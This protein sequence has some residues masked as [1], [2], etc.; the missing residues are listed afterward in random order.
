M[1][2]LLLP[3][4]TF[5]FTT[6]LSNLP[7]WDSI[8]AAP[9]A[10]EQPTV[11]S[12][13]E[14]FVAN[15]PTIL[16]VWLCSLGISLVGWGVASAI[17]LAVLGVGGGAAGSPSE[18]ASVVAS[19]ISNITQ[20]PFSILSSFVGV[21]FVAVP[22]MYYEIGEPIGVQQAFSILFNRPLRYL[23][24]GLLFTLATTVGFIL[25]ILPGIAVALVTPVYVNK[26]FNT[27]LDVVEA[28]KA[29][30]SAVYGTERGRTFLG[31]EILVGLVVAAVSICTCFLGGLVAIP[32]GTFYIQNAAYRQG[33]IS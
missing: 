9:I 30:F 18:S 1:L 26:I 15:L 33:V 5:S 25:C 32:M 24:A 16:L 12:S 2:L 23:L 31:I 6:V 19:V 7:D 8:L 28:L 3:A 27:E 17:S 11:N 10:Y 13:W 29:S 14:A 22:A 4:D 21:L 20:L